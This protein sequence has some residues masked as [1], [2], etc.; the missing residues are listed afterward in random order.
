MQEADAADFNAAD[1]KSPPV[2]AQ[3]NPEHTVQNFLFE[4]ICRAVECQQSALRQNRHPVTVLKRLS[5]I[6][7]DQ[8]KGLSLICQGAHQFQQFKLRR[9]IQISRGFI[10]QNG[11]APLCQ[12]H[13]QI[14]PLPFA[15]GKLPQIPLRPLGNAGG[16]HG[17]FHSRL[18]RV[19][20]W[21]DSPRYGNRHG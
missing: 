6:V 12:C 19:V 1:S 14:D 16:L 13:S 4:E 8:Q 17:L 10:Q 11:I 5:Q 7:E 3:G 18:S 2:P 9:N 21:R 15:T 20:I